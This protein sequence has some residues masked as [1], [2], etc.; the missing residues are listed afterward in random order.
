MSI[1]IIMR[2]EKNEGRFHTPAC[3]YTRVHRF[4]PS[5]WTFKIIRL[6]NEGTAT[7]IPVQVLPKAV[8]NGAKDI[9]DAVQEDASIVELNGVGSERKP[10]LF[11]YSISSA[12]VVVWKSPIPRRGPRAGPTAH[13]SVIRH[14]GCRCEAN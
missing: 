11:Y 12:S 14:G 6:G 5:A 2:P 10:P 4:N 3:H 9:C 1:V 8:M 13:C 7:R